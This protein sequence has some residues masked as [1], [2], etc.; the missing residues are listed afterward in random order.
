MQTPYLPSAF[1]M[2]VT[3][4]LPREDITYDEARNR[5]TNI[6][7]HLTY[8]RAQLDFYSFIDRRQKLIQERVA[9]Y[10]GLPSPSLC[11]VAH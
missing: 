2:L 5:E 1:A 6:L 8:P 11:R 3:L 7:L 4:S 9:R 10:L